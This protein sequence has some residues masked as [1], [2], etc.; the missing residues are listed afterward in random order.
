MWCAVDIYNYMCH[1]CAKRFLDS[2]FKW[3]VIEKISN[4]HEIAPDFT[5]SQKL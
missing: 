1:R 2:N 4:F 3:A 5:Y